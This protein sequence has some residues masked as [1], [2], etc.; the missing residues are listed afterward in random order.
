MDMVAVYGRTAL[1]LFRSFQFLSWEQLHKQPWQWWFSSFVVYLSA[2]QPMLPNVLYKWSLF[3][4]PM[5]L[6]FLGTCARRDHTTSWHQYPALLTV[7]IC[8]NTQSPP[9]QP[10][11]NHHEK[12]PQNLLALISALH[13]TMAPSQLDSPVV[14]LYRYLKNC[15]GISSV[16]RNICAETETY[17]YKDWNRTKDVEITK[18]PLNVLN[19]PKKCTYLLPSNMSG[20]LSW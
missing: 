5:M 14:L 9:I 7:E 4:Q 16:W 3:T 13:H 10:Y 19:T 12:S 11:H 2:F 15:R 20:L 18:V 8:Q 17:S 6:A 1:S